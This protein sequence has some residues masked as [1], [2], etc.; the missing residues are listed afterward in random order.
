MKIYLADGKSDERPYV[1][2]ILQPGETGVLDRFDL[3][4]EDIMSIYKLR[5]NIETFFGWWKQ[6][7][8]VYHRLARS[9]YG[10]MVQLLAGLITYILLA[11]YCHDEFNEP[12]SVKRVRQ[13][14]NAFRT[15]SRHPDFDPFECMIG[16]PVSKNHSYA[17]T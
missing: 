12:V 5:L 13:L 15:E 8:N 9:P 6:H 11:I 10:M 2:T 16:K 1:S 7:L 4:A 17:K 14:R 3:T